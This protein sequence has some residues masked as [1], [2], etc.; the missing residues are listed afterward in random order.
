M[1][2]WYN[3]H[4]LGFGKEF[5]DMT[6]KA[7]STKEKINE[8]PSKLKT[9]FASKDTIK[10]WKDNLKNGRKYLQIIYM[11]RELYLEYIKNTYNSI[12]KR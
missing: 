4:D 7:Q 9:F 10:K 2:T 12:I 6:P 11:I 5:L 1:K 3:L 8:I